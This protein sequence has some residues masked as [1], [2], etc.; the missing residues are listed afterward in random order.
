MK[1]KAFTFMA[2]ACVAPGLRAQT[3]TLPVPNYETLVQQ[4][5]DCDGAIVGVNAKGQI[6]AWNGE[7]WRQVEG[8][9]KQISI[10][11]KSEVWGVNSLDLVW[12]L[13]ATGWQQMPGPMHRVAVSKGGKIVVGINAAGQPYL[14]DPTPDASG[15]GRW[16]PFVE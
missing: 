10:G 8:E 2:M 12:K 6:F 13:T 11:S 3:N 7:K 15:S 4:S 9:L 16:K 5:T 14:W 1:I